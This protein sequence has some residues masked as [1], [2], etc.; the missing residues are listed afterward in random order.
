MR[1][2]ICVIR[3]GGIGDLMILSSSL[4]ELKA[5]NPESDL[6]LATAPENVDFAHNFTFVDRVIPIHELPAGNNHFS[7]RYDLRM[8][9][10]PAN[11]GEGKLSWEKYISMDRSDI[12]DELLGVKSKKR[13]SLRV[14]PGCRSRADESILAGTHAPRIGLMPFSKSPLRSMPLE[15]I[16]PLI[17]VLVRE[18]RATVFLLGETGG[19]ARHLTGLKMPGLVNV[20]NITNVEE[21]IAVSSMLDLIIS[22]DS[23]GY[24]MAA[25]LEKKCLVLFGNIDPMTR[26]KHYPTVEALYPVGEMSCIPCHDVPGACWYE[27]NHFEHRCMKLLTPDR[28]VAKIQNM[29][30][31]PSLAGRWQTFWR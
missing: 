29:L 25:A 22:V 27:K 31:R 8:A 26:I 5:Q 3:M 20:A 4:R 17:H 18:L 15:Y 21:S 16:E 9:V 14:C 2:S 11:I 1:D 24:H 6:V 19:W 7:Q 13:F 23:F 28:I 12:F 10:E 30:P